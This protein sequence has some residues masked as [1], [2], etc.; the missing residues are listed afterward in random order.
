[1]PVAFDC[2]LRSLTFDPQFR[3]SESVGSCLLIEGV[4]F[5]TQRKKGG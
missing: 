1:V 4:D 3:R 2:R 5:D